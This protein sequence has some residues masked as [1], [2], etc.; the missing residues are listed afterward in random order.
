MAVIRRR[1]SATLFRYLVTPTLLLCAI[2]RK[3]IF[4]WIAVVAAAIWLISELWMAIAARKKK[5]D[6]K[7]LRA[8]DQIRTTP[9]EL[10]K[11]EA[12]E[13]P[14][15]DLFL[16]RQINCRI[17]EQ[18]KHSYPMVAWIWQPRPSVDELNNGG[19][20]RIQLSNAD[21]FN[22]GDVEIA[23]TGKL[24][25]TLLQAVPL[26]ES[27]GTKAILKSEPEDL[28]DDEILD[29]VD[30]KTWYLGHGEK[31]IAEMIDDLNSQGHKQLLIKDD[32]SV[33][34]TASGKDQ[35]V[36]SIVDFPPRMVW[37]EFCQLLSEDD[38]TASVKPEGLSLAW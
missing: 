16:I 18:L 21:P 20:W 2:F 17:T 12:P 13:M 4:Q 25:I 24:T 19:T 33:I 1:K 26:S 30:A 6:K 3:P 7:E 34:I 32:G 38:I 29:R 15:R 37:E 8:L 14:E 22:Y 23:K 11:A 10:P 9:I 31:I 36:E 27:S 28:R 35:V 5:P